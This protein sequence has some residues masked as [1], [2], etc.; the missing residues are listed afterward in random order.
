LYNAKGADRILV[1]DQWQIVESGTHQELRVRP[2]L[3]R[4]M[5][6]AQRID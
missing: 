2:G 1:L 5:W 4:A 3:Y 6:E